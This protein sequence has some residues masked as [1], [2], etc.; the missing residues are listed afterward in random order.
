MDD[1][2]NRRRDT[3]YTIQVPVTLVLGRKT[4]VLR[5]EDVSFRGVFLRTDDPPALRQLVKIEIELPGG[6][7]FRT[8][9]MAVWTVPVGNAAGR[10]P[11]VGLQFYGAGKDDMAMWEKFIARL[12][13]EASLPKAAKPAAPEPIRRKH[14][15]FTAS[16][17]VRP[18]NVDRLMEMYTRDISAG[19]MFLVTKQE[20]PAEAVIKLDVVHPESEAIFELSSVVRRQVPGQGIGVEFVDMDDV[21]REEFYHFIHSGI[22]ELD[23]DLDLVDEDDPDLA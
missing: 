18:R 21:R 16:F 14:A 4:Y 5:T 22:P 20:V 12:K 6:A 7:P 19:G 3:R 2:R 15:R 11:G 1:G 10:D 9:A 8:A 17:K 13:Q 23:E